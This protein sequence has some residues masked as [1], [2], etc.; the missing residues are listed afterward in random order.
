MTTVFSTSGEDAMARIIHVQQDPS[1]NSDFEIQRTAN[2]IIKGDYKR[3]KDPLK[4]HSKGV[5]IFI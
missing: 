5:Y 4:N 1:D 2:E 3:V